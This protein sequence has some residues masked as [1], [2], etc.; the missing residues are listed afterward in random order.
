MI[1]PCPFL[2]ASENLAT[3]YPKNLLFYSAPPGVVAAYGEALRH[4]SLLHPL[5][6][7]AHQHCT[8]DQG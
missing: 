6:P 4:V 8:G 2:Q 3:N 7:W 1:G 5:E